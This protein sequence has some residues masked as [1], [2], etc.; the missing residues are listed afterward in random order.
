MLPTLLNIQN[1]PGDANHT[2]KP[3]NN[4]ADRVTKRLRPSGYMESLFAFTFTKMVQITATSEMIDS[5][6]W[7]L[8]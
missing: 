5:P 3:G 4:Q 6:I 1:I 2:A 8:L 7:A